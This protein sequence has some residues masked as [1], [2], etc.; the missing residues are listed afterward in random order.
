MPWLVG[1]PR[2]GGLLA[3]YIFHCQDALGA[4]ADFMF[5][6]LARMNDAHD[7]RVD[8][9]PA[10]M[11]EADPWLPVVEIEELLAFHVLSSPVVSADRLRG[12]CSALIPLLVNGMRRPGL[13]TRSG[14]HVFDSR[15]LQ[16]TLRHMP[17]PQ[18]FHPPGASKITQSQPVVG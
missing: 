13:F 16:R 11:P 14:E 4:G 18:G 10:G 9:P 5:A 3:P 12:G 7:G 1:A 8:G 17:G 15:T 2:A 6:V